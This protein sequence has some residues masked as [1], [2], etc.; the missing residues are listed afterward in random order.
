MKRTVPLVIAS[1]AGFVLVAA[2]FVPFAQPWGEKVALWFDIIAAFAIVLGAGNLLM[3]NLKKI[4]GRQAG[5]GFAL[6]TILSFLVTLAVGLFKVGVL[7]S[8]E[9]P[10]HPWAGYYIAKGSALWWIYEYVFNP[11][12]ATMFAMLAFF[13]ASAAFR[14]F[15]AKNVEAILLL[16][17]AFIVLIGRTNAAVWLTGWF[18]EEWLFLPPDSLRF[19]RLTETVIMGVFNLSG[20]RA[21]VIGIALGIV[22]TSL[23]VLLGVDRPYL[24][25]G[26]E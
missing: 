7:P 20:T 8:E 13:M 24:G 3:A 1:V 2:R 16:G 25:S 14:A 23:K 6:V 9:F 5:W 4:S 10:N 19:D 22:A 26:R 15:R 17:T 21:I 18:P 11:L 12:Q